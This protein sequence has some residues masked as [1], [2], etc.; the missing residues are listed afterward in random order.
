MKFIKL[1]FLCFQVNSEQMPISEI[2]TKKLNLDN[3]DVENVHVFSD[4]IVTIIRENEVIKN[5][6]DG[7]L[8]SMNKLF[9]IYS[10]L[11]RG[12]GVD[13][14]KE[15]RV[16]QK[17]SKEKK[18]QEIMNILKPKLNKLKKNN[19]MLRTIVEQYLEENSRKKDEA[20]VEKYSQY[21][22]LEKTIINE[23]CSI[24]S[25]E[26]KLKRFRQKIRFANEKN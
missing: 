5:N 26:E 6:I 2:K 20:T 21:N 14:R 15:K 23:I 22:N 1:Y 19:Y 7:P 4:D 11:I 8:R 18:A 17:K 10:N 12:I 13:N 24:E 3:I 16:I 9:T 25:K